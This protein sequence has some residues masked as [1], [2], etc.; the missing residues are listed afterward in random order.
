M[1]TIEMINAALVVAEGI[2]NLINSLI[3]KAKESGELTAEQ[4]ADYQKRQAD[5][6]SRDYS[7]P[8]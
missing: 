5:I 7:K 8:E 1:T 6:Y 2:N 4:E 3:S